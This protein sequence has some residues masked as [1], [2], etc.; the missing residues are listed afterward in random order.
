MTLVMARCRPNRAI[1]AS[2]GPKPSLTETVSE[3]ESEKM[4]FI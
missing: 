4:E 3:T 1:K 2:D